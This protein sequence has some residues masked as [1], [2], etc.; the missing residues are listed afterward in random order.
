MDALNLMFEFWWSEDSEYV[1]YNA[2]REHGFT[3]ISSLAEQT[4]LSDGALDQGLDNCFWYGV[5]EHVPGGVKVLDRRLG[6]EYFRGMRVEAPVPSLDQHLVDAFRKIDADLLLKHGG[7]TGEEL[8]AV[9]ESILGAVKWGNIEDV[10]QHSD[11]GADV[12]AKAPW[13]PDYVAYQ[14]ELK[15]RVDGDPILKEFCYAMQVF[16]WVNS[17]D[18]AEILDRVKPGRRPDFDQRVI[19][20]KRLMGGMTALHA[21]K[22]VHADLKPENLLLIEDPSIRSGYKL[23]LIDMDYSVLSDKTAPWDDDPNTEY[24]GTP[25]YFSPEHLRGEAPVEAS[26][27]F[28]CSLILHELLGAGHPYESEDDDE[29]RDKALNHRAP[30]PRLGGVIKAGGNDITDM[31][32][33][34]LHA[35]LHPDP[36]QRPSAKK[37]CDALNGRAGKPM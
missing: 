31:V 8:K 22:I 34:Y 23:K 16:G 20:A 12:N 3:S 33:E 10:K 5:I 29:Y 13:Y 14:K 2:I 32:A 27:V 36:A 37:L 9:K 30:K 18:L 19:L 21:A 1:V 25:N 6:R 24:V 7:K 17:N 28:T 26:D 35:C 4:G 11:A 15:R